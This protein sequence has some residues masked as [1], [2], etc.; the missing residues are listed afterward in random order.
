MCHISFVSNADELSV[1]E[2]LSVMSAEC[3]RNTDGYGIFNSKNIYRSIEKEL[4][5]SDELITTYKNSKWVIGHNRFGTKGIATIENTHPFETENFVFCHNGIISNC[6]ELEKEIG[7]VEVDSQAIGLLLEKHK[8]MAFDEMIKEAAKKIEGYFSVFLYDKRS[9]KLYY[10]KHNANFDFASVEY[11][12]KKYLYGFTDDEHFKDLFN[13]LKRKIITFAGKKVKPLEIESDTVYEISKNKLVKICD[14]TAKVKEYSSCYYGQ[15]YG[16]VNKSE[17]SEDKPELVTELTSMK[18][19]IAL[20]I[21]RAY[22]TWIK[23]KKNQSGYYIKCKNQVALDFIEFAIGSTKSLN[24]EDIAELYKVINSDM[25]EDF[26]SDSREFNMD[27]YGNII[28]EDGSCLMASDVI[29]Y[30]GRCG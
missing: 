24:D 10:F 2:L 13:T 9:S 3:N 30:I 19:E 1:R 20:F 4:T 25:A 6:D 23:F 29:G 8:S 12:G 5:I 27:R 18:K 21:K 28:A 16:F 22:G 7:K 17:W 14:F 26:M 15:S 11:N